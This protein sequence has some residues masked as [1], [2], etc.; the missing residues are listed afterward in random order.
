MMSNCA[1][2]MQINNPN[3]VPATVG[4]AH[5]WQGPL[6]TPAPHPRSAPR[7]ASPHARTTTGL[8]THIIHVGTR[9]AALALLAHSHQLGCIP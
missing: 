2:D 5:N 3:N 4:R 9:L 6:P 1:P 8:E 7:S